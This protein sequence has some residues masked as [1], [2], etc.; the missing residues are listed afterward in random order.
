MEPYAI[1]LRK[2][3]P[4]FKRL[5]DGV[6]ARLMQSSAFTTP[7]KQWFQPSVPPE[8]VNLN[9]PMSTELLD[10]L[11]ATSDQPAT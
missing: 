4:L 9:S 1:M 10:N 7:Y 5:V 11:K 6:L 3:D 8:N 2:E